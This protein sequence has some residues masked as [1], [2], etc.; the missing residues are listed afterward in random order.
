LGTGLILT[1]LAVWG[2]LFYLQQEE[3][4]LTVQFAEWIGR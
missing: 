2:V 1:V 4:V 3:L